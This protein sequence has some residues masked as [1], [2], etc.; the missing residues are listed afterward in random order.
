MK[1]SESIQVTFKPSEALTQFTKDTPT[2]AGMDY[3]PDH[4][5][6]LFY[7]GQ[8]SGAG[9][10]YIVTPNDGNVWDMSLYAF[11]SGSTPPPAAGGAGVNNRFRYLPG[12]KGFVVL[13]NAKNNLYFIRTAGLG[14]PT[15]AP[16]GGAPPRGGRS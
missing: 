10:I 8:G 3:D 6:F 9:R 14:K 12:L 16:A 7:C 1:G 4:D 5:R 13:A 2:Y 11:G 15:T